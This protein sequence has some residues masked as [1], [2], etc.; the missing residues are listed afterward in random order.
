MLRA[1]AFSSVICVAGWPALAQERYDEHESTDRFYITLGGF[2]RAAIRTTIRVDAKTPLGGILLGTAIALEKQFDLDDEVATGRLHGWYRFNARHRIGLTY[3]QSDREGIRTYN[4]AESIVIG[5]VTINPGDIITTRNEGALVA[6]DWSYSFVNT[7]K[8][9]AWVGAGLNIQ[10][11]DT[12]FD[13]SVGGGMSTLQAGAKGTVPIPTL[14]LGGRWTFNERWRM[15]VAQ[16][17]FG[18]EVS[19]FSGQLNNTR[20]LAEF[21]ITRRFGI[22]GG[23]ERYSFEVDAE[24]DNF[25]GQ[26]DTSY[27]GLSLYLKGQF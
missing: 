1:I 20:I 25:V 15:I 13:V 26:F 11:I 21:N 7:S 16:E 12:S 2:S 17:L 6:V 9:E 3:W 24:G 14:N 10:S 23:F 8:Y 18:L 22:G 5:D 19:D 4:G 27:T